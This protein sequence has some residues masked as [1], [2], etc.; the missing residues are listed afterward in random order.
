MC[1]RIKVTFD[2]CSVYH[3]LET[4]EKSQCRTGSLQHYILS[5][6]LLLALYSGDPSLYKTI[7]PHGALGDWSFEPAHEILVFI[8]YAYML[9]TS[10]GSE[11]LALIHSLVRAFDAFLHNVWTYR[12]R[13]M[14]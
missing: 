10:E 11:E 3:F 6:L 2:S 5:L 12:R 13:S 9:A 8:A 1:I 14:P 4:G 7:A